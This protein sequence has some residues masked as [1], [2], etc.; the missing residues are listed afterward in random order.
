MNLII[1]E[2]P[3]KAKTI[4]KY[5]EDYDIG[6]E[7]KN[8]KVLGTKGHIRNIL[9]KPGAI[10]TEDEGKQRFINLKWEDKNKEYLK[11]ILKEQ[12]KADKIFIFT[13]LDREGETIGWHVANSIFNVNPKANIVRIRSNA[14]TPKA[15][16][17]AFSK[18]EI[19]KQD[20]EYPQNSYNKLVQ[21]CLCRYSIDH[22][23]GFLVSGIL[24]KK[25][26]QSKLAAGR[27]KTPTLGIAFK[28]ELEIKNFIPVKYGEININ[29]KINNEQKELFIV[30]VN[31]ESFKNHVKISHKESLEIA[32]KIEKI[33]LMENL[34][35]LREDS[36]VFKKSPPLPF[37]T[38]SLQQSAYNSLGFSLKKTMDLCKILYEGVDFNN[39]ILGLITYIRTDSPFIETETSKEISDYI[40]KEYSME[41]LGNFEKKSKKKN[42][43]EAHEAIRPTDI[44]ITPIML[45]DKID[46]DLF[47]LYQLIWNRTVGSFMSDTIYIT[48]SYF[49]QSCGESLILSYRETF[50]QFIGYKTIYNDE[51]GEKIETKIEKKSNKKSN[52]SEIKDIKI[53]CSEKS[54]EAPSRFSESSILKQ[55]E[56]EGV[57][58]PSTYTSM[59]NSLFEYEFCE[60]KGSSVYILPKGVLVYLFLSRFF[61]KYSSSSFTSDME[62]TLDLIIEKS[63]DWKKIVLEFY[64]GL[65][66]EAVNVEKHQGSALVKIIEEDFFKFYNIKNECEKCQSPLNLISMRGLFIGCSKYP[67]CKYAKNIMESITQTIKSED[68]KIKYSIFGWYIEG[69]N[70]EEKTVNSSIP[71]FVHVNTL[72]YD[73]CIKILNFP[74]SIGVYKNH[75]IV[76]NKNKNYVYL[77]WNEEKIKISNNFLWNVCNLQ[78]ACDIIDSYANDKKRKT[79]KV[80]EYKPTKR[81]TK[82]R[83]K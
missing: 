77:Q 32:Y 63:Q 9:S 3:T 25:L 67:E 23:Y 54:T 36:R 8:A 60:K 71:L 55:M 68:F 59:I 50:I 51:E 62:Q 74:K 42:I 80:H 70:I 33:I 2:S 78:E 46:K 41:F 28:R 20:S 64:E 17:E 35:F 39:N 81:K 44:K 38:S 10:L 29:G 6:T 5:V 7:T 37:I 16:K 18:E 1:V 27:V 13:D 11:E 43:Q 73:Q 56:N 75:E 34:S 52:I 82:L 15:L 61:Q 22:L 24:L 40:V 79:G 69:K 4:Q 49:F 19:W 57:G 26:R 58:R 65:D 76:I 30:E 66:K 45:K 21:S 14:I 83:K 48:Y 53:I 12:K 47:L 31:K 72:T